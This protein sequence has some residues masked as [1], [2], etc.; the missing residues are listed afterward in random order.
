[1]ETTNKMACVRAPIGL[2]PV[3]TNP[4]IIGG[5]VQGAINTAFGQKLI[6]VKI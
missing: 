3:T 6:S 2:A 5:V 4:K 1:M